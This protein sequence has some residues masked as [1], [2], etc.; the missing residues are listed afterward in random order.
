MMSLLTLQQDRYPLHRMLKVGYDVR[1]KGNL[2]KLLISTIAQNSERF[3]PLRVMFCDIRINCII[4][5]VVKSVPGYLY[6]TFSLNCSIFICMGSNNVHLFV[7]KNPKFSLLKC[8]GS[9]YCSL[10]KR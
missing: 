7:R 10:Q 9:K 3:N 5:L 4:A 8:H 1:Q 6:H 2:I